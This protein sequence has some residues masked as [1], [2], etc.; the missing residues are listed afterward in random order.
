MSKQS[1]GATTLLKQWQQ[2]DQIALNDLIKLLTP[3]LR[4]SA[5]GIARPNQHRYQLQPTEL[6]NEAM[7]RMLN[8]ESIDWQGRSHFLAVAAITMR[9]V[10]VDEARRYH[11]AKRS[12]IE[13]TLNEGVF[14]EQS[15]SQNINV[16]DVDAALNALQ[17]L[18]PGRAR[19][20]EL[21]FFAGMTNEEIAVVEKISLSTV[22][23]QWRAA[24]VWIMDYL[25]NPPT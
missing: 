19:I 7:I 14:S 4:K 20:V 15:P 22:K 6:I 12:R 13:V 24:R 23:R 16:I 21:K 18:F 9:R 1:E 2:G 5:I 3:E 25:A 11:A 8:I 10:L 17:S